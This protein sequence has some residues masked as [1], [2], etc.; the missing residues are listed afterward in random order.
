MAT[1]LGLDEETI[2]RLIALG[3]LGSE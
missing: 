3:V 2:E 1:E